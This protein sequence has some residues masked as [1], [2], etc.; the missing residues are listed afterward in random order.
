M[1]GVA[2]LVRASDCGS[3]GRGFESRCPPQ[4]IDCVSSHIHGPLAQLVEQGTLNPKVIGSIPIRPTITK[5]RQV[6]ISGPAFSHLGRPPRCVPSRAVPSP[7]AR[8]MSGVG[9]CLRF[10]EHRPQRAEMPSHIIRATSR[11]ASSFVSPHVATVSSSL[12]TAAI[13]WRSSVMNRGLTG[14]TSRDST[15]SV[16]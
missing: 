1:V 15:A 13:C 2:Q 14:R 12:A 4:L 6:P 9:D 10:R 3:E 11:C 16:R 7:R 5:Q 8:S